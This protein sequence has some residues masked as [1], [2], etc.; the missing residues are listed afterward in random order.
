MMEQ[1]GRVNKVL[2]AFITG[3]TTEHSHSHSGEVT[4]N[5]PSNG[6]GP[7]AQNGDVTNTKESDVTKTA[8]LD[9]QQNDDL[10]SIQSSDRYV[11]SHL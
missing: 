9:T 2:N 6:V 11:L 1:P 8:G 7:H 4:G 5:T 10:S 3:A